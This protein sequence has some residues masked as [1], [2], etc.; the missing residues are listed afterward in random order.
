MKGVSVTTIDGVLP[1]AKGAFAVY[2]L[3]LTLQMTVWNKKV[4]VN[5]GTKLLG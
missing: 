3:G 1:G 2:L 4:T 5:L